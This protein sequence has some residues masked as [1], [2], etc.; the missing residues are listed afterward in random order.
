MLS[1]GAVK[2]GLAAVGVTVLLLSIGLFLFSKGIL[3]ARCSMGIWIPVSLWAVL[4]VYLTL[5]PLLSTWAARILVSVVG[6]VLVT[7]GGWIIF[8]LARGDID[9]WDEWSKKRRK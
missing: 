4:L 2:A 6:A 5:Y 9:Q 3:S 1:E 8:K 7:G